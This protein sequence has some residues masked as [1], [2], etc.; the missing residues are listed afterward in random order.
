MTYSTLIVTGTDAA[1][2]SGVKSPMAGTGVN[3]ASWR[4]LVVVGRVV[5]ECL[6][7]RLLA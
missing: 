7:R 3:V 1:A 4:A 2:A 5:H 6:G